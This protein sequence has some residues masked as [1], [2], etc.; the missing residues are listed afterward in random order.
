MFSKLIRFWNLN[1]SEYENIGFDFPI[2][3]FCTLLCIIFSLS[4]FVIYFRT[5]SAQEFATAL[6]RHEAYDEK[7]A[8]TLL[9]LRLS[10]PLIKLELMQNKRLCRMIGILG[11][12][13]LSYEEY[14]KLDKKSAKSYGKI[15]YTTAAFY[16]KPEYVD[17][18]KAFSSKNSSSLLTPIIVSIAA[19]G[20]LCLLSEFLPGLLLLIE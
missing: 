13:E 8:K 19:F 14:L 12:E 6:V 3:V 11:R 18:M 1:L 5:R 15:D 2:G 9:K 10:S 20:V 17:E 16:I 4:L 7:T